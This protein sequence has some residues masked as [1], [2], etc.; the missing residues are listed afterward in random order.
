MP[1]PVLGPFQKQN[2]LIRASEQHG[3]DT[4]IPVSHTLNREHGE[5]RRLAGVSQAGVVAGLG[6]DPG[7]VPGA[8]AWWRDPN[9]FQ[10]R[11]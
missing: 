11:G 4:V 2:E 3:E 1:G 9:M 10:M 7:S 5:S 8:P 6:C